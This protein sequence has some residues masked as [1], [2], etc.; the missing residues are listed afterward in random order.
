MIAGQLEIL[1]FANI[2]R[3]SDDMRRAERVVSDN[4]G[5]V[6]RSVAS[7]K[8]AMQSLGMGLSIGVIANTLRGI[9]DAYTKLDAQLRLSTK[10]Q[11]SYN[12]ALADIRHISQVAQADISATSMLYTR[13]M[14]TMDG[15]G[16]SQRKLATVTET[17]T[18]GLKAYGATSAEAASAALQLSQAMGANRLG[19]EEF[20]AVMEAM[21]NVMKVLAT[22]M[23]VSIGELR[24]LSIAGKITAA[25]MVKAWGNPEIAAQFRKYAENAQ[26][27]TGAMTNVRNE[28]LL[29]VGEFAK[30]TGFTGGT[31][32]MFNALADGVRITATYMKD[33]VLITGAYIALSVSR[34]VYGYVMALVAQRAAALAVAQAEMI[35]TN[36]TYGASAASV[37]ASRAAVAQA[38]ANMTLTGSI[39]SAGTALQR[40]VVA[41]P[42][43]VGFTAITAAVVVLKNNFTEMIDQ[44][45][46]F[47]EKI[48]SMSIDALRAQKQMEVAAVASMK[49]S[50]LSGF[51]ERDIL[52]GERRIRMLNA[53]I[54]A[55][56]GAATTEE[57][58][59]T[60]GGGTG[61][62][63]AEHQSRMML[64]AQDLQAQLDADNVKMTHSEKVSREWAQLKDKDKTAQ[65][66]LNYT[67]AQQAAMELDALEAARKWGDAI[68]SGIMSGLES[69]KGFVQG[70]VDSMKQSF[71]TMVLEPQIKAVVMEA[72]PV[73]QFKDTALAANTAAVQANTAA[74]TGQ[75]GTSG[76]SSSWEL[77]AIIA[78]LA[79]IFKMSEVSKI[80]DI[81]ELNVNRRRVTGRTGA[82]FDVGLGGM[83]TTEWGTLGTIQLNKFNAV[84]KDSIATYAMLGDTIGMS[85]VR[86]KNFSAT[87]TTSGD[88]VAAL[89]QSIGEA[90][91]PGLRLL[92]REGETLEQ[93]AKR[94]TESF[95]A[96][97]EL[98][99]ALG[100]SQGAAFGGFGLGSAAGRDALIAASGGLQSFTTNA[101]GF[102]RNFLTP[103]QQMA[104]A[105]DEVGRMF[106]R[107][108]IEGVSTN[109]QFAALVKQQMELGNTD[110]VAQ[111]LAVSDSFN[112]V[113]KSAADA[114]A[115]IKALFNKD[116]FATLV[117]Y[118]RALGLAGGA[119]AGTI[120]TA[121]DAANDTLAREGRGTRR[122][123]E[124]GG[125]IDP[126]APTDLSQSG[127]S[128]FA[129]MIRE[130]L[131]EVWGGL[132]K[133]FGKL[134]TPIAAMQDAARKMLNEWRMGLTNFHQH[135]LKEW[136]L[137]I[138]NLPN[139][140]LF[141]KLR[142][143][144]DKL[145]PSLSGL[146]GNIGQV[147][148]AFRLLL[149]PLA[150]PVIALQKF[151]DVLRGK[152]GLLPSLGRMTNVFDALR[153]G[154]RA[155]LAPFVALLAPLAA[156]KDVLGSIPGLPGGGGGGGLPL[157]P[158]LGGLFA[159]GAAFG[160]IGMHAFA[161]GGVFSSPTPF[162]FANGAGFS[163]GVMGEAGDEAVIPLSR[164]NGRLGVR[165]D[166]GGSDPALLA[167]IQGLRADLR[168]S[169]GAIALS[170][171]KSR[172]ILDKFDKQGL[173]AERVV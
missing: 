106:A 43:L 148:N 51:Y 152:D 74:K 155:L 69:S 1:L 18:F 173:P 63:A 136:R 131:S 52:F 156:L 88:V 5:K 97:N 83:Q 38:A 36:M 76:S 142:A 78:A 47:Q 58:F 22:S 145:M 24:N 90:L 81:V 34:V 99:A 117:D 10:S 54:V 56:E 37:A 162:A 44:V 165:M 50:M 127:A 65:E 40:F 144:L 140:P 20:R 4:M 48:R 135:M 110:V 147:K 139:P 31:I 94:V 151:A 8:Q 73:F 16:V 118:N 42:L 33:L 41:N 6:E 9:S 72:M 11:Q 7:A 2:A 14:N 111:L 109:E 119:A 80:A 128:V 122:F 59:K 23:G 104:P 107:L 160:P 25:E 27:I 82:T 30:A 29:L 124:A 12:Q 70:F 53:Q 101:Q 67:I 153:S 84:A 93:T 116:T 164:K 49:G 100:V 13:L 17:I 55:M 98:L 96:T 64:I 86:T 105:L 171:E 141:D 149:A 92:Q 163:L 39:V 137:G 87:I 120:K 146:P 113:T 134:G 26:T 79:A 168:A 46:K 126:T 75:T 143:S 138:K 112:T 32:A 159:N 108:G 132:K 35:K 68:S 45:G 95:R 170:S 89:T 129:S 150:A 15:T 121:T 3:L 115:Q 102:I 103:A 21:P 28:L 19:G 123:T 158:G 133:L 166:G 60:A 114:A 61:K 167:E 91:V 130:F 172:K 77:T 71:K 169:Q 57:K 66:A 85:N 125:F 154:A 62:P 157:P 161:N